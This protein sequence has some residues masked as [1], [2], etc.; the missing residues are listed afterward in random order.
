MSELIGIDWYDGGCSRGAKDHVTLERNGQIAISYDL[1]SGWPKGMLYVRLGYS[2]GERVLVLCPTEQ[3]RQGCLK[4]QMPANGRRAAR[5]AATKAM[6][7]WGLVPE[8]VTHCRAE[9]W[10]GMLRVTLTPDEAVPS[11]V[12]ETPEPTPAK[13]PATVNGKARNCGNCIKQQFRLCT[14]QASPRRNT[15]V[16]P[17]DVCNEHFF[18]SERRGDKIQPPAVSGKGFYPHD[19]HGVVNNNPA[20][21]RAHPCPGSGQQPQ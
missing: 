19:I 6:Q 14:N 8:K 3:A 7:G 12:Q 11:Q 5:L 21:D 2:A 9:W 20:A 13:P 16:S 1:L 15:K 18:A 10:Q 4:V 17:D